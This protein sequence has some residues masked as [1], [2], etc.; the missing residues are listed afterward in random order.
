[1]KG[2]YDCIGTDNANSMFEQKWADGNIW[3]IMLDF[4]SIEY[5]LPLVLSEGVNKG[6]LSLPEAVGLTFYGAARIH[7]LYPKKGVL[8]VGSDAD[9]VIVDLNKKKTVKAGEM[10]SISDYSLYEGWEITGWPVMTMIRGKVVVDND[11][12]VAEPGYGQ[13][14]PCSPAYR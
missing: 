13:Y 10:H 12:I 1:M 9:L 3:N 2:E 14:M 7:G 6:R 5:M 8:A 4:S 11:K